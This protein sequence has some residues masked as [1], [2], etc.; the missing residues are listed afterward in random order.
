M[1]TRG[2]KYEKILL[3]MIAVAFMGSFCLAAEPAAKA[4][5]PKIFTGK[6]DSVTRT[7]IKSSADP[8]CKII[9][10]VDN[11]EKS[12][13][14]IFGGTL[15]TDAAGKDMSVGGKTQ[16]GLWLKKGQRVEIKYSTITNGSDAT[17]GQNGAFSIHCLD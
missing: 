10:V 6:I 11:G 13:F 3:A 2:Q 4:D 7:V 14:F 8:Y 5:E 17:N 15:V 1:K 9:V 12:T 16:G